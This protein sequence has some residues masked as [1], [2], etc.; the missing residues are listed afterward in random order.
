MYW[1]AVQTKPHRE[2]LAAL[3][4]KRQGFDVWL[5]C[6]ENTVRH[7]RTTR[8]VRRPLFPG[9]LFINLDVENTGWR[10]INGTVGVIRI[11]SFGLVPSAVDTAFVTALKAKEN[12]NGF[13]NAEDEDLKLGQNIKILSGPMVGQVASLLRLDA[14]NRITVLFRM[15]GHL[16]PGQIDREV[17]SGA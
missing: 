11:V 9:Y 7:A 1:Y 5:P 6:V 4:L 3:H 15:L 16:V 8:R 17:V 13:L 14:G 10:A 12:L 2:N